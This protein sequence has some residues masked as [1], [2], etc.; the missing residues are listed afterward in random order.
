MD[1]PVRSRA[2]FPGE[3]GHRH[4]WRE[5]ARAIA[6]RRETVGEHPTAP[7]PE[8]VGELNIIGSGI[9]TVGFMLG[10]E[11]LLRAADK[12][13]FCV[14]DPAT[15][16]WLK[17]IRPDAYDL[18]VLYDDSK[19]RYVTYMQMA[20]SMLHFVREGKRVV[21]VFYGHPGV[22]VL[23]THRAIMIARREGHRAV[24]RPAVSALDC[25]CAD[26]GV[27]PCHP[28]MQT[29]EATDMLVRQRKPDTSLHVV[30]WQVGL[31]GEMGFRR[32]GYINRN[33]SMLV[34]Y[35][36]AAYGADYPITHYVASRYPT[37][38]PLV[39]QY[40]LADLHD[41]AVQIRITGLS[42]F[43]LAPRDAVT[44]DYAMV[45]Q[46]GLLKPGQRLK[47]P[48][49]ALREIGHYDVRE[50][51][52][53]DDFARF[54]VPADYQWQAETG[55]A[56]FLIELRQDIE[57]QHRYAS[58][59]VA[60]LQDS[61]FD[62]LSP[63]E[64]KLLA[65]R[66]AGGIQV[67]AKG[68]QR[69]AGSNQPLLLMLLRDRA[70]CTD[71]VR[72]GKAGHAGMRDWLA[73][74]AARH[75]VSFD[76]ARLRVDLANLRRHV[77]L[78]WTGVYA[79]RERQLSIAIF[80][81][82]HGN[83]GQLYVNGAPVRAFGYRRGVLEWRA[84]GG[85]R[86]N[87]F[88]RFDIGA[89]GR[90]IIGQ[91]W[92]AT[93][94]RPAMQFFEA[95]EVDPDRKHLAAYVNRFRDGA[96]AGELDGHYRLTVSGPGARRQL[97]LQLEGG[98]V[99]LGGRELRLPHEEAGRLTWSDD[100]AEL[101]EGELTF[102]CNPFSGLAEFHGRVGQRGAAPAACYGARTGTQVRPADPPQT[103]LPP[104]LF[105]HLTAM[106]ARQ[107]AVA[108]PFLWQK[109]EKLHLTNRVVNNLAA[110]SPGAKAA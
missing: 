105:E 58:D 89:A 101:D 62:A 18:Y 100:E 29:H 96:A 72:R 77:L 79:A 34:D 57:L 16:V 25:L 66:D 110:H 8:R 102:L 56:D 63:S 55:A 64:R 12:V 82:S 32:Q 81:N 98:V 45:E 35:L 37:I 78:P 53:F 54:D 21:C 51:K 48:E 33:F 47:V 23:S 1:Q 109:W 99:S 46:L 93:D 2:N 6:A 103:V 36:Q 60:A 43:Y 71:L 15:I 50:M 75:E 59:P 44:A 52:A 69:Q 42:T 97:D 5:L 108:P 10:D 65:S 80:A 95:P 94:P 31:I 41:P 85:N 86:C 83:G 26:L 91:I 20:E 49:G 90:R 87:G 4:A 24:M 3:E 28:G 92:D 17:R 74:Y 11:E 14:A 19:P 30:L 73:R 7:A 68:I 88:L 22:F 61:R 39:E 84:G 13:F 106:Y 67:A 107:A 104:W 40:R 27:D 38:A 9:E 70:A 76:H